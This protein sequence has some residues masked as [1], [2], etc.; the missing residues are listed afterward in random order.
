M[1]AAVTTQH[2]H[3][4]TVLLCLYGYYNLGYPRKELDRIY[5]KDLKTIDN[6]MHAYELT[7]TFQRASRSEG[8]SHHSEKKTGAKTT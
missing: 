2:A 7:G 8:R 5:H 3:P 1:E 4:N 6:W